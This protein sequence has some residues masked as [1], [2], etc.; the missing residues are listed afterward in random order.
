MM[1]MID[2]KAVKNRIEFILCDNVVS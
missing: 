1:T 2:F